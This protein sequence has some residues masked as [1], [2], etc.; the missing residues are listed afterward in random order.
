MARKGY[1][2]KTIKLPDGTRKYVYGRTKEELEQKYIEACIQLRAGVDLKNHD[3]FGEFT[4]MWWN[5]FK[6]GSVSKNTELSYKNALNKHVLPA[7]GNYKL[8]DITPMMCAQV[9]STMTAAGQSYGSQH[10][11]RVVMQMIFECAVDNGIIG[12]SPMTKQ[13]KAG[14]KEPVKRK[15]LEDSAIKELLVAVEGHD[16][17]PFVIIA[18]HT[19]MRLGEI[20]GLYWSDVDMEKMEINVRHNLHWKESP[21]YIADYTKTAAG[22]RTI[23]FG[24]AVLNAFQKL[25]D[26]ANGPYVFH[27]EDGGLATNYM[28]LRAWRVTTRVHT[29]ASLTPHVLRHTA[30]TRWIAA[31]MDVKEAQ[32][33][34]GHSNVSTTLGI[35]SDYLKDSRMDGT[36][37]KLIAAY[38]F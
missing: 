13:V 38:D 20:Y 16:I 19:G 34:A 3:S 25:Q 17:E 29:G 27:D 8:R 37:D 33:L 9:F 18:L 2:S 28:H 31:S 6:K 12:R 36:R 21:A 24:D 5:A 4:L 1:Y 26:D 15:A 32:Y 14:G 35:Y 11:V 23:P 10:I 7:L 22:R 30:I